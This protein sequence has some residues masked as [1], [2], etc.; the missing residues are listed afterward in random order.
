MHASSWNEAPKGIQNPIDISIE[1]AKVNH[2]IIQETLL[3]YVSNMDNCRNEVEVSFWRER[4]SQS[5]W[6]NNWSRP[7]TLTN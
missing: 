1:T 5:N 3:T 2:L 7:D 6:W 4:F